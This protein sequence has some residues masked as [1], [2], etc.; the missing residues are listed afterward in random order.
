LQILVGQIQ[1]QEGFRFGEI[2]R[3]DKNS[4]GLIVPIIR[5]NA[6]ERDYV[7]LYEV[8]NDVKI[9][10]T[11]RINELEVT[12]KVNK[13][14][15]IRVGSKFEGLGTQSR[16]A[17]FSVIVMPETKTIP[18]EGGKPHVQ[19]SPSKTRI[20]VHCIHASHPI[21][22]GC[23]F[24]LCST[25]APRGVERKFLSRA[26]QSSTWTAVSSYY[27]MVATTTGGSAIYSTAS[28]NL[29]ETQRQV[30]KFS[31]DIEAIV[32]D[33]PHYEDQVG[34][35]FLDVNGVVGLE[36][37]DS[38]QSW[39]A[40]SEDLI[41]KYGDI[42]SKKQ[43]EPIFELREDIIPKKIGEFLNKL[44]VCKATEV[45]S[46]DGAKTVS[47]EGDGVL[48]EYTVLNGKV[49]HLLGVREESA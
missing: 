44:L 33:A 17:K 36:V 38:P 30:D 28:D 2:W 12:S 9:S 10:D 43:T 47:M 32:K 4:L 19:I 29:I 18:I 23:V 3:H 35:V 41:K 27:N 37:F 22:S 5:E 21:R 24:S 39:T 8:K 48:G 42:L 31:K 25:T 45:F 6:P 46:E 40:F 14:V 13:P 1:R 15:F 26:D 16:A 49:I 7:T 20:P 34:A 11:G